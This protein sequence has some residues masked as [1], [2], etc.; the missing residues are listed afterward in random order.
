MFVCDI[1]SSMKFSSY[2]LKTAILF[3]VHGDTR[4]KKSTLSNCITEVQDS[5]SSN[6]FPVTIPCLFST[7]MNTKG[8]YLKTPCLKWKPYELFKICLTRLN[9][10]G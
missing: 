10:D 1:P 8:L 3:Q 7:N 4:R 9:Y 2:V 5:F 6:M